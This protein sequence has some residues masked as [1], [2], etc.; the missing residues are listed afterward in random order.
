MNRRISILV[1]NA[2]L[3][4]FAMPAAAATGSAEESNKTL[5]HAKELLGKYYSHS[6]VRMARLWTDHSKALNRYVKELVTRSLRAQYKDQAVKLSRVIIEESAR[7]GFDPIFL[8][9]FIQ[10][11][12]SFNP[13]ARGSVGELGLMQITPDTASWISQK[14]GIP[15]RGPATLKDPIQN[16]RLGCAYLSYLRKHFEF[17]GRLYLAAYN[18]GPKNVDRALEKQIWPEDYAS[19]VMERYVGFYR[20]IA[21]VIP[22]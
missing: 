2:A 15:Y 18:M 22:H 9:A 16:I 8:V 17:H 7:H 19:R 10:N 21:S 1:M 12:S 11:E 5:A 3:L 6:A 4:V 13:N 14:S 20:G